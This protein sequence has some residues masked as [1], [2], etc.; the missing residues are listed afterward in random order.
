MFSAALMR[1]LATHEDS[2]PRLWRVMKEW[3]WSPLFGCLGIQV[4][5]QTMV[6]GS[7]V[8]AVQLGIKSLLV[9]GKASGGGK[10]L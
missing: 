8:Y 2:L 7:T 3:D 5:I 1:V 6:A 10:L 9:E 4:C